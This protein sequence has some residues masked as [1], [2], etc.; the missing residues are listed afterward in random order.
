MC[1]ACNIVS[2]LSGITVGPLPGPIG[3]PSVAGSPGYS[4]G[5]NMLGLSLSCFGNGAACCCSTNALFAP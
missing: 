5:A 3:N 2:I 4:V 1:I